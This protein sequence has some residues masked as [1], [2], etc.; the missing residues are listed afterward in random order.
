M[1]FVNIHV[2]CVCV[3]VFVCI[4]VLVCIC[5]FV[6]YVPWNILAL[7]CTVSARFRLK[8]RIKLKATTQLSYDN[9]MHQQSHCSMAEREQENSLKIS[10]KVGH[11]P[12]WNC[13]NGVKRPST[14]SGA[15]QLGS[16]A[17]KHVRTC[18]SCG[19]NTRRSLR[20]IVQHGTTAMLR[21]QALQRG[22]KS[23][24]KNEIRQKL[25]STIDQTREG[26]CTERKPPGWWQSSAHQWT[27][28]T[29][30][31]SCCNRWVLGPQRCEGPGTASTWPEPS[32]ICRWAWI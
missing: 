21:N 30:S 5:V 10:G 6:A 8:F 4:C 13:W 18:R 23:L 12:F 28:S 20:K 32:E 26:C 11:S 1:F 7:Y 14:T 9:L 3:C 25:N 31:P 22:R 29:P 24:P 19:V 2:V 17:Q 15:E 27:P 16:L